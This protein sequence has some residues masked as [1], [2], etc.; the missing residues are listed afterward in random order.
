MVGIENVV[1]CH[2]SFAAATCR[3]CQKK[4]LAKDIQESIFKNTQFFKKI[5]APQTVCDSTGEPW[6]SLGAP[7][8][9]RVAG[10]K[11]PRVDKL[12][13]QKRKQ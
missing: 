9:A 8:G 3:K 2:G 4:Y 10:L 12:E 6:R 5:Q 1:Q 7:R 13:K 11:S